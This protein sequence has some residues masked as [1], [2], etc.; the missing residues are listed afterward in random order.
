MPTRLRGARR[1]LGDYSKYMPSTNPLYRILES[2]CGKFRVK[3]HKPK[4]VKNF[5][6]QI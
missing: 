2:E 1:P 3:L 5:L 6:E 4:N